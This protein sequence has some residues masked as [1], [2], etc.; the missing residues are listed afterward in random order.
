[1]LLR[2]LLIALLV[3]VFARPYLLQSATNETAQIGKG[4]GF[5][6][7]LD[8]SASM[9]YGMNF[10][11]MKAEA[12]KKIDALGGGDRMAIVSFND[13]P[14]VLSNPTTDKGKLK[15]AVSALEP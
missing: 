15:A 11:K 14:T 10:D 4:K 9:R 1:M 7:L 13:N 8:N 6:M 5:V 12:L 3:G 2:L